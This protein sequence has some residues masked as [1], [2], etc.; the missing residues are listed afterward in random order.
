[1]NK[2]ELFDKHYFK[3]LKKVETLPPPGKGY[4]YHTGM[5]GVAY[6]GVR[7]IPKDEVFGHL[8]AIA[9]RG[10]RH[11]EDSEI[12]QAV[13]KAWNE[14]QDELVNGKKRF[15]KK[16]INK[17]LPKKGLNPEDQIIKLTKKL[18]LSE[19]EF[20]ELSPIKIPSPYTRKK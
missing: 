2:K 18:T 9:D 16:K 17:T 14:L 13:E 3:F 19:E 5:L 6:H 20:T 15:A 12:N 8:R 1:M 10:T 11:V 4:G 7:C